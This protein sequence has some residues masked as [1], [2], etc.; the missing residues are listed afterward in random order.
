MLHHG[1]RTEIVSKSQI[2]L[3]TSVQ[4]SPQGVDLDLSLALSLRAFQGVEQFQR[5][6]FFVEQQT[7]RAVFEFPVAGVWSRVFFQLI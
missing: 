5:G 3:P 6:L 2:V 7:E 1:K 4:G